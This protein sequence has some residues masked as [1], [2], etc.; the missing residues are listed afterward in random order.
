MSV[1]QR[2]R[3]AIEAEYAETITENRP[4]LIVTDVI[5]IAAGT[6]FT[7]DGQRVSGVMVAPDGS[8]YA[9]L[10]LLDYAQTRMRAETLLPPDD[11]DD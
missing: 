7:E 5:V 10:G 9:M 3:E 4:G 1:S 11:E 2:L 6:G 8:E